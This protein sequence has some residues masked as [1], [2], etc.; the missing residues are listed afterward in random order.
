MQTKM[1]KTAKSRSD[2]KFFKGV[3]KPNYDN[4]P[5]YEIKDIPKWEEDP[6]INDIRDE[7][8]KKKEEEKNQIKYNVTKN[9]KKNEDKDSKKDIVIL[10]GS[11]VTFD[12]NGDVVYIKSN[13]SDKFQSDFVNPK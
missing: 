2:S 1:N 4:I 13:P 10:N 9:F 6:I 7:V 11:K 8:L 3:K 12:C 5:T